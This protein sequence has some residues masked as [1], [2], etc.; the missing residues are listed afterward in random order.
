MENVASFEDLPQYKRKG[1]RVDFEDRAGRKRAT[2]I[3][4]FDIAATMGPDEKL[5][6]AAFKQALAD[7]AVS[8]FDVRPV[9]MYQA[10]H[11]PGA[12]SL[13]ATAVTAL[14]ERLPADRDAPQW[15]SMAPAAVWRRPLPCKSSSW[16]QGGEDLSPGARGLGGN[17]VQRHHP[18]VAAPRA[19]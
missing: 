2:A 11:V 10:A 18:R 17:R 6:K 16:I 19:G 12:G 8:V 3:V 15:C 4:R 14:A 1:F 9:P 7:A 13:P 5:S